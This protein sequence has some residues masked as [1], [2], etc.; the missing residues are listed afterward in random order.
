M[1]KETKEQLKEDLKKLTH[2]NTELKTK[3]VAM[4]KEINFWIKR[5]DEGGSIDFGGSKDL[6][7]ISSTA[8]VLYASN[9]K[10]P[11]EDE[12]PRD[13]SDWGRCERTI[14]MI[15]HKEWLERVFTLPEYPGWKRW[16]D[17]LI[18][19]ATGRILELINEQKG[20]HAH[21]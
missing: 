11:A 12:Y 1:K 18:I 5:A 14:K 9:R 6:C 10:Q 7:G 19:A 21:N 2:L 8:L 4:E 16:E 20:K 17:K 13:E 15:P 3:I